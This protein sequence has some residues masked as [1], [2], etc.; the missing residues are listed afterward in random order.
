MPGNV[1]WEIRGIL[2]NIIKN[3]QNIKFIKASTVDGL[4]K[5]LD[6]RRYWYQIKNNLAKAKTTLSTN[7]LIFYIITHFINQLI[8]NQSINQPTNQ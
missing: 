4:V 2:T 1:K 8:I 7:L 5:H 3:I 6:V